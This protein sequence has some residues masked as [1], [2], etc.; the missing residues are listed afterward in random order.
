MG[1]IGIGEERVAAPARH[2]Q[3]VKLCRLE[4]SLIVGAVGV[5]AFGAAPVYLVAQPALGVELVDPEHRDLGMVRMPSRF[6]W[7]RRHW[8]KALAVSDEVR[9]R[10]V[11]VA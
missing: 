4:R 1:G 3:R 10:Q 9:D 8:P 2:R 5:P 6:R 11:L 7:V